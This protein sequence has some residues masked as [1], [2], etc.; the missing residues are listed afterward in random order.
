M[1][2]KTLSTSCL[3]QWENDISSPG[4][5]GASPKKAWYTPMHYLNKSTNP[6]EK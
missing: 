2:A 6:S 5:V 4:T 3:Q 1:E